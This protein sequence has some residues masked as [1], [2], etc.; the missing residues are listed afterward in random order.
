MAQLTGRTFDLDALLSDVF[1][2]IYAELSNSTDR[3]SRYMAALWGKDALTYR[4]TVTG[5]MFRASIASIAPDGMMTL[6]PLDGSPAR[7]Y[8]FKEV[9][10]IL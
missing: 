1:R 7:T 6:A 5:E 9:A 10:V 3:H 2:A 8:A 4:D